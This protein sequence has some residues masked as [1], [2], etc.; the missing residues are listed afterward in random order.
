[1][2]ELHRQ[3]E[4]RRRLE[5]LKRLEEQ[6]R[7]EEERQLEELKRIEEE[8]RIEEQQKMEEKRK[9]EEQ[10]RLEEERRLEEQRKVQEKER[11]I[12]EKRIKEERVKELK[13]QEEQ[14]CIK[15]EED[16][17]LKEMELL[18]HQE[19]ISAGEETEKLADLPYRHSPTKIH[20]KLSTSD[21][22]GD[23]EDDDFETLMKGL[24][25]SL[26]ALDQLAEEGYKIYDTL[27]RDKLKQ[28]PQLQSN[29]SR[30]NSSKKKTS[31]PRDSGIES[32]SH[33]TSHSSSEIKRSDDKRNSKMTVKHRQEQL[34][35]KQSSQHRP[36]QRTRA[37]SETVMA[38]EQANRLVL[39]MI[40]MMVHVCHYSVKK[41][42]ASMNSYSTPKE[43]SPTRTN[44]KRSPP[45]TSKKK[46]TSS[47]FP[48]AKK[49]E[50]LS[51]AKPDTVLPAGDVQPLPTTSSNAQTPTTQT[52]IHI[53]P[54][55]EPLR[56][57]TYLP[58]PTRDLWSSEDELSYKPN[59]K[60]S[61]LSRQLSASADNMINLD[62]D[63]PLSFTRGLLRWSKKRATRSKSSENISLIG[64]RSS[65]RRKQ[66]RSSGTPSDT[67][68]LPSSD[69]KKLKS[70]A[71]GLF[72]NLRIPKFGRQ[73]SESSEPSVR[74]SWYVKIYDGTN[75]LENYPRDF[76]TAEA[77]ASAKKLDNDVTKLIE[78]NGNNKRRNRHSKYHMILCNH[79]VILFI[80][81]I[82]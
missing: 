80:T 1:L 56:T 30:R 10:K 43:S 2:E 77:E 19:I 27:T 33:H 49:M 46:L 79:Y 47:P 69:G 41:I 48:D 6:K 76:T 11:L 15:E 17:K 50:Q 7:I 66:R 59:K 44:L 62:K 39:V 8:R 55:L 4:E 67:K 40:V 72:T 35:S 20:R 58:T 64:L 65:S 23:G 81:R 37:N 60:R 36:L 45:V 9:L 73:H 29:V 70:L 82:C 57:S 25:E 14:R 38:L 13:R 63:E 26:D 24:T 68:T 5:E 18:K 52:P 74:L 22:I 21:S 31:L 12:E 54:V 42:L 32:G 61:S 34:T 53:Q 71:Q 16:R 75:E 78:D 28:R 3:E 51:P